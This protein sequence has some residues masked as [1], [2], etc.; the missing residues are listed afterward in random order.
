MVEEEDMML[1]R[2][3]M[4]HEPIVPLTRNLH[5]IP[6]VSLLREMVLTKYVAGLDYIHHDP[7]GATVKAGPHLPMVNAFVGETAFHASID[8]SAR[9]Y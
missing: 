4:I 9:E 5:D 1:G 3:K 6:E 8:T 2:G 7:S